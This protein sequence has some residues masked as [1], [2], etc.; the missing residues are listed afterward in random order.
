MRFHDHLQAV[1]KVRHVLLLVMEGNHN[2]VLGHGLLI[3]DEAPPKQVLKMNWSCPSVTGLDPSP[4][5]R[6][7][8]RSRAEQNGWAILGG[9][10]TWCPCG[11]RPD[12][13]VTRASHA[14]C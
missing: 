5:G 11:V 13:G 14:A 4:R 9:L 3:I 6:S 12:R 8:L 1:I 7:F 10:G 2:R